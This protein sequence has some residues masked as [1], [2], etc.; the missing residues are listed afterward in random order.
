MSKKKVTNLKIIHNPKEIS[1]KVI[2]DFQEMLEMIQRSLT[3][4]IQTYEFNQSTNN[5]R[6][7]NT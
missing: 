4:K 6:T 7:P 5:E 1:M 2:D 3:K